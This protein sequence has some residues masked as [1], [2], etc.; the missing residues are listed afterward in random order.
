[1]R[2]AIANRKGGC[3]KT[4]SA[5]YLCMAAWMRGIPVRL[6]DADP[7]GSATLWYDLASDDKP[8]PFDVIPANVRS[9]SRIPDDCLS[10]IDCPADGLALNAAL[11]VADMII[12]PSSDS[13]LDVQQTY[14]TMKSLNP[15]A[16]S[17]VLLTRCERNTV[18]FRLTV[19]S[20]GDAGVPRF[21]DAVWKRQA[22]K[23]A[24]GMRPPKLYEYGSVFSDLLM[25]G[26]K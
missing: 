3:A 19:D 26:E 20:L 6:Y 9:V 12:V 10:V 16:V 2:I 5:V 22:I 4:T 21:G 11:S 18:S 1:M 14:E 24:F 7:Q 17:R 23:N 8:L 13:P 25:G 15:S